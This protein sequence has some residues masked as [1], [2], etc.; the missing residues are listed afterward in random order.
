MKTCMWFGFFVLSGLTDSFDVEMPFENGLV[1]TNSSFNLPHILLF[2][3]YF[4]SIFF[5]FFFFF[6]FY[7][8][9]WLDMK[10]FVCF[11]I[12][13]RASFMVLSFWTYYFIL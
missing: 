3:Y 9:C 8:F 10:L 6:F 4:L 12:V 11:L 2:F 5:F 13:D 1:S 7:S